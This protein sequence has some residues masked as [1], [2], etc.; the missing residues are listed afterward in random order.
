M[1]VDPCAGKVVA[2][3]VVG[4]GTSSAPLLRDGAGNLYLRGSFNGPQSEVIRHDPGGRSHVIKLNAAGARLAVAAIADEIA[5]M[6]IGA[7]GSVYVAS[8]ARGMEPP[9]LTKLS[10]NLRERVYR[11]D[12]PVGCGLTVRAI[13]AAVDS[14]VAIAGQC[15]TDDFKATPDAFLPLQ[16]GGS[17]ALVRLDAGGDVTYATHLAERGGDVL[18]AEGGEGK[19]MIA[20]RGGFQV[21]PAAP[22]RSPVSVPGSLIRVLRADNSVEEES[23]VIVPGSEPVVHFDASGKVIAAAARSGAPTTPGALGEG[24]DDAVTVTQLDGSW[25]REAP[26]LTTSEDLIDF[27]VI[28]MSG[29]QNAIS[30]TERAFTFYSTGDT[31]MDAAVRVRPTVTEAY[32]REQFESPPSARSG[33]PIIVK[34]VDALSLTTSSTV[35]I[36]SAAGMRGGLRLIPLSAE[37]ISASLSAF[38]GEQ[39]ILPSSSSPPLDL[40][41]TVR[42]IMSNRYGSSDLQIPFTVAT[43]A[44]W[45][46]LGDT[47]GTTPA[48]IPLQIDPADAAAGFQMAQLRIQ[49]GESGSVLVPLRLILGNFFTL[50]GIPIGA[51]FTRDAAPATYPIQIA[52]TTGQSANFQIVPDPLPQRWYELTPLSGRTPATILLEV[53]P[54]RMALGANRLSFGI[55]GGTDS[56]SFVSTTLR[57]VNVA[58]GIAFTPSV[59][60]V[61]APGSLISV[62]GE[63]DCD[64]EQAVAPWPAERG[65][66]S[67][68]LD[69][70]A[71]PLGSIVADLSEL[72]GSNTLRRFGSLIAQMP[73]GVPSGQ[74][75]LQFR[76]KNG[77]TRR[78]RPTRVSPLVPAIQSRRVGFLFPQPVLDHEDGSPVTAAAPAIPGEIAIARLAGVGAMKTAAPL[79]DVAAGDEP[80]VPSAAIEAYLGGR[81]LEIVSAALS[82]TDVGIVEVRVRVPAL[83]PGGHMLSFRVGGVPTTFAPVHLGN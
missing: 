13:L 59:S 67:L 77:D 49:Y 5:A 57:L 18:L 32:L 76:F 19:L 42:T 80:V 21:P 72:A 47:Q 34:R 54:E 61:A 14:R 58:T 30:G 46:K 6:T 23:T 43:E 40:T 39:F 38:A 10:S 63:M 44:P 16:P 74:V 28:R 35:L 26:T 2:S 66:C 78:L 51:T 52:T 17:S 3:S 65:G 45:V 24:D 25:T 82:R 81:R 56:S 70:K 22:L 15:R 4:E 79:G 60:E 36:L 29:F 53:Y 69:G 48:R 73:Y 31:V 33:E 62:S 37:V 27:N 50:T 68:T 55:N 20:I 75:E 9:R 71:L 64:S 12:V 11:R 83:A 1:Q 41:L 7:D 8:S